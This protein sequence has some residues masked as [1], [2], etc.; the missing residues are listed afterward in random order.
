MRT[1]NP[2]KLQEV[3]TERLATRLVPPAEMALDALQGFTNIT[4]QSVQLQRQ[5]PPY[6]QGSQPP[7]A[8]RLAPPAEVDL[9]ALLQEVRNKDGET[10]GH[11]Q[12][13]SD[14][15]GEVGR[16]SKKGRAHGSKMD[17]WQRFRTSMARRSTL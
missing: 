13:R 5:K 10:K 2:Q 3:A 6:L 14:G 15:N 7:S 1:G 8:A 9:N 11:K 4:A 17:G 16:C 12:C